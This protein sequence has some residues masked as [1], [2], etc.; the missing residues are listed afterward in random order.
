MKA[1]AIILLSA[2]LLMMGTANAQ[3]Q[4]T[5]TPND[6]LH[7]VTVNPDKSVILR[8]YAPEAKTV[9]VGGDIAP[10]GKPAV[11]TRQDN[12]V[13]ECKIDNDRIGTFRYNFVVD[14]LQV[15]RTGVVVLGVQLLQFTVLV[16]DGSPLWGIGIGFHGT[17]RL[18]TLRGAQPLEGLYQIRRLQ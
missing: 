14:G 4:R 10:Y 7:S 13:W 11:F 2:G 8:I 1:K 15:L 16:N 18:C 3:F 9:G 12:G 5:P 17:D 6:T